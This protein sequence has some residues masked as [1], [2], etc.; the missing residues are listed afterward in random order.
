MLHGIQEILEGA[1]N[2][3]LQGGGTLNWS[4]LLALAHW[5]GV[6][7]GGTPG[8]VIGLDLSSKL[9]GGTIPAA[10]RDLTALT[11]LDLAANRLTGAIPAELA[12][13]TEPDDPGA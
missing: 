6:T 8:R 7:T 13:L 12:D 2:T 5:E 10:L 11:T 4:D 3:E 9:L 1:S